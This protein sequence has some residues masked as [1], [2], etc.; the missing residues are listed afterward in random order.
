M[1]CCTSRIVGNYCLEL[2]VFSLRGDK[3]SR[4]PLDSLGGVLN[5]GILSHAIDTARA[6]VSSFQS[7][8]VRHLIWEFSKA[9]I[10]AS[11]RPPDRLRQF[12]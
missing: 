12:G 3:L 2:T 11:L 4:L 7:N 1:A 9:T 5:N 6:Q 8:N 10:N